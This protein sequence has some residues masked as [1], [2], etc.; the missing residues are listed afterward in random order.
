MTR[1]DWSSHNDQYLAKPASLM[2]L[3]TATAAWEKLG[4][5]FQF[6]TSLH[7]K[8]EGTHQAAVQLI[9]N[10]DPTLTITDLAQL[11][12]H[13]KQ[14]GINQII[15]FDVDD[16]HYSGH[17]WGLGQVW[18]DHGICFAAPVTAIILDHNCVRGNLRPTQMGQP[19]RLF[20]SDY[21]GVSFTNQVITRPSSSTC[22]PLHEVTSNNH[23]TL[24]GCISAEK[25]EL[26]LA[27]SVVNVHA[28]LRAIL[29][30]MTQLEGVQWDGELHFMS[31]TSPYTKYVAHVSKPL[32]DLLHHMLKVSDNVIADSLFKQLAW[33]SDK[34]VG[35]YRE[36]AKVV[37]QVL[38]IHHI[39]KR[40]QVMMD[41]SGLSREDLIYPE[42]FYKVLQLWLHDPKFHSL[43]DDLPISGVDGTLRYR[44]SV[45][46]AQLKGEIHAK[47]GSMDGVSNLAGY[48]YRR[49]KLIPFV[50]MS[51]QVADSD[52][53][54]SA[55]DRM[56]DYEQSWLLAGLKHQ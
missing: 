29:Q 10:G 42:T 51:N 23:F 45:L 15:R 41:G 50:L 47:T 30:K 49:G 7:Y 38:A 18:N 25:T 1:S 14:A 34:G 56:K 17:Q 28:Y 40:N 48:I 37:W 19:A 2:K 5:K 4:P 35:T 53:S 24:S 11:V 12:H 46:T 20:V 26:P 39:A 52:E 13:L 31:V 21:A 27:F 44:H 8:K 55:I 36:G 9:F 22:E 32:A 3:L 43:I 6:V 54:M 33:Q 16:S